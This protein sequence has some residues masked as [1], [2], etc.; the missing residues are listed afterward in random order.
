M[1][2][3]TGM[4]LMFALLSTLGAAQQTG[5]SKIELSGAKHYVEEFEKELSRL[6]G[7]RSNRYI[8]QDEAAKR[9]MAL[10]KKYPNDPQVEDLFNRMREAMMKTQGDFI[11]ITPEML[12]YRQRE[13]D[14]RSTLGNLA[15]EKWRELLDEADVAP[16]PE[17]ID[18]LSKIKALRPEGEE[19]K[20]ENTQLTETINAFM[21]EVR[22]EREKA[23]YHY[24]L[25]KGII[26]QTYPVPDWRY[27]S[28]LDLQGRYILL[29]DVAYPQ[30]QFTG[31]TGEY[32]ALGKPSQGYWYISLS[33]REWLGA[34]EAMKRCRREA[35]TELKEVERWTVLGKITG[36]V[37]EVPQSGEKKTM[38]Y[39][40]GWV[41]TPMAIHAPGMVSAWYDA[42][43]E[44]SGLFAGE[45]DLQ[46]IKQNSYSVTELPDDATP[47]QVMETFVTAIKEKNKELY[48]DCIDPQRYKTDT[49]RDLVANYHW[50]LHQER[51]R[52]HYVA[53]TFGE[54]R[55]EVGEGFD[56]SD[57][58]MQYFLTDEQK[59]TARKIGGTRVER[60][61]IECKAWDEN[62]RQ[63]GSP[64]QYELKRV[65]N[66]PWKIETYDIPF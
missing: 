1:K 52:K 64:K 31:A 24:E 22:H 60:A 61:Y 25:P 32:I 29:D 40:M 63:Y 36:A 12:A 35:L 23:N 9:V 16:L 7:S 26:R 51:F 49:G 17:Q 45:E 41:V 47:I 14:L 50:D 10:H 20:P 8:N 62:G 43:H 39:H 66:G 18:L 19:E 33:G 2:R 59:E 54:P 53:V 55:I 34:W 13:K 15:D 21:E 42:N 46:R 28:L 6:K 37:N 65:G 38:G 58:A 57:E 56:E 5:P 3:L 27:V 11:T 44:K 48:L 30:G 4:A